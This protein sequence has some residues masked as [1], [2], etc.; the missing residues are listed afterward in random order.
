MGAK[1]DRLKVALL[2]DDFNPEWPSLPIVGFKYATALAERAEV[3]VFTQIRNK[4]NLEKLGSL[5][6]QIRYLDTEYIASPIYKFA[7]W[8]RRGDELG[9]T[10][11]IASNY[12]PYLEF[13]R[14]ALSEIK[15]GGASFD[16]VHRITPMSP[17]LPSY[18]SGRTGTPFVI[19]PLN[20]NL[21]WPREFSV[22]QKRER[23]LLS[24]F[25]G[26]Y[27]SLPFLRSTFRNASAV[28]AAFPHTIASL[29]KESAGKVFDVPEIG[30]DPNIFYA[31]PRRGK[32]RLTFLYAGRLVP[33]KLPDV[34]VLAFA[35]RKEL[36]RHRLRIVGSGPER[37][38]LEQLV[39]EHGL[40]DCVEFVGG[41]S[42]HQVADE[43]RRAD[44]FFF[45]SIR[46][47]GAGVVIEAM[48]CGLPCL[49][50]DYGA[51][52][53]LVNDHRGRKVALGDRETMT[54]GFAKAATE[55]A[56]RPALLPKM[57]Q[58]C[59]DYAKRTFTWDKK[60]EVTIAIYEWVLGRRHER[61]Q[62]VY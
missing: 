15:R 4:K 54:L 6:F 24:K 60:A 7:V 47:L 23:E 21:P 33:Y 36:R 56:S 3:T 14:L 29:G 48:A 10:I 25:K 13:E 26:I 50:A 39:K 1:P 27:K 34:A 44:V 11:Q 38:R 58:E 53:A 8:L 41:L 16:V 17:T 19:G 18:S 9:W 43:M 45:P 49:V 31:K 12:L 5:G 61:P 59:A 32:D 40:Q 35:E 30:Y 20:G 52:G 55:L 37:E 46:E 51:P 28:L 57:S 62:F 22:E 2:A 42:Q